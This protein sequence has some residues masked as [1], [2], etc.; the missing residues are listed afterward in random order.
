MGLLAEY[1]VSKVFR[2]VLTR[3]ELSANLD[4]AFWIHHSIKRRLAAEQGKAD[5]ISNLA[6]MYKDGVGVTQD[7][8]KALE[9]YQK[10]FDAGSDMSGFNAASMYANGIGT[11][12]DLYAA[13]GLLE[14][15]HGF[16]DAQEA[17]AQVEKLIAAQEL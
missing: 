1:F 13:R 2:V 14:K 8:A 9:L 5:S 7:F 6:T 10:A 16:P 12:K 4:H 17:L 3:S 11:E 15:I